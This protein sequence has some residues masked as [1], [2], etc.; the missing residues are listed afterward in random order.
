MNEVEKFLKVASEVVKKKPIMVVKGGTSSA[1]AKA[2][3]SH[4]GAS[5]W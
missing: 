2:A 3:G 4:T 1:G 5:C